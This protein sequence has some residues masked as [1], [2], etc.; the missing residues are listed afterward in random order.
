[1]DVA[2]E[3]ERETLEEP[4]GLF[5]LLVC[6]GFGCFDWF[7]LGFPW[8]PYDPTKSY[9]LPLPGGKKWPV[10]SIYWENVTIYHFVIRTK[11]VDLGKNN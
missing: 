1:M 5:C 6:E 11:T 9:P 10:P 4:A 2:A 7:P 3:C 8:K